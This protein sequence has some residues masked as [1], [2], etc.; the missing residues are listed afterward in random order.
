MIVQWF[1]YWQIFQVHVY[2]KYYYI[3]EYFRYTYHYIQLG[4]NVQLM[5]SLHSLS[6]R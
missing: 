3:P 2:N 4:V 1:S 5:C 6:A